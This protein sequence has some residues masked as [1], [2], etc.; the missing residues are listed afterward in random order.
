M[1]PLD[2]TTG[3]SRPP[4]LE[5]PGGRPC[6]P[7]LYP[8]TVADGSAV[9][10]SAPLA[11]QADR[12]ELYERAV[13]DPASEVRRIERLY[14]RRVGGRPMRLRED[15][16][17]TGYLS[18]RWVASR[19]GREAVGLDLDPAPLASGR[20]RHGPRLGA[21]ADGWTLLQRDVRE[22]LEGPFDVA[23]ALNYSWF[24]FH[25]RAE[26]RR[27]LR[28]VHDSLHPGGLVLLDALG[29]W[30]VHQPALEER[31]LG[32]G[33]FYEWEQYG[34]DP[35]W[36]RLRCAIHFR[37]PDG[38]RLHRAFEYDWRLW[39]LPELRE[40]LLEAGFERVEVLWEDAAAD[41]SG[42][43]RFRV[44]RAVLDEPCWNA[45]VVASRP[46]AR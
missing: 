42:A 22:P 17:G 7:L 36:N 23:V 6:R 19:R 35:I 32:G 16:C 14:A 34:L 37:F 8:R 4:R 11:A 21:R 29:G 41:G 5:R 26:L 43:G 27:Y 18:A 40:L 1:P 30:E 15:F 38:S 31:H 45:Y 2:G 39:S 28:S 25:E 46:A 44:R 10:G 13:Q 12:F 20:D 3:R 9:A 24:V 33:V